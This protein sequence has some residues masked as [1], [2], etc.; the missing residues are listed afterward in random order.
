[1]FKFNHILFKN[2]SILGYTFYLSFC[3]TFYSCEKIY[4]ITF[5]WENESKTEIN[6]QYKFYKV[7]WVSDGDTFWIDDGTQSGQKIR[8]IGIDAPESIDYGDK[9][10][11]EFGEKSHHFVDSILKNKK[12]RLEYDIVKYDKFGRTLA[13]AFLEDG[14]FVNSKIVANGYAVKFIYAPN[15]KYA[16]EIV[17]AEDSAYDNHLGLWKK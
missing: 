7:K 2:K 5:P 9:L 8:L 13:Y 12:V 15:L 14:T 16:D 10:K 17:Q 6:E 1:M 3:I 4:E 11:E